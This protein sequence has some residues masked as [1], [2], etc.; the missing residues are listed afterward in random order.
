[1]NETTLAA[2]CAL[3]R[4]P[5]VGV[6]TFARLLSAFG[7]PAAFFEAGEAEVRAKL[8]NVAV[9]KWRTWRATYQEKAHLP[10]IEWVAGGDNRH[11]ITLEDPAYPPLL[12]EIPDPPPLLFVHGDCTALLRAQLAVVGSRHLTPGACECGAGIVRAL[13]AKGLVITSGLALGADGVAHENALHAGGRTVAVVATGLD[14]VYPARHR[15]LAHQIAANGA[16][17]SEFPIATGVR[18]THF[19]RRNRIISGLSLGVFVVEASRQSGS[20]ITARH[21][22]EQ[23]REVFAMPGSVLNPLVRGCHEL[24]RQGA[25]LV[26]QVEDILEELPPITQMESD[27]GAA[28][29][30]MDSD[31]ATASVEK[32]HESAAETALLQAIGYDPCRI[33]DLVERTRLTSEQISAMLLVFELDGRVARLPGGFF[34]RTADQKTGGA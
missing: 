2:W 11:I 33:D 6:R 9:E 23:G 3:W 29:S 22:V 26:E 1:M 18:Q 21:A 25:K 15:E 32:G 4:A 14:R 31:T 24:I 17:V 12:K 16:I 34:Q 5:G 30:S 10:D 27:P 19:P 20:L 8:A 7:S 28:V 13:V